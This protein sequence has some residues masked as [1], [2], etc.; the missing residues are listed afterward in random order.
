[1]DYTGWYKTYSGT[2]TGMVVDQNGSV[3]L[4][5]QANAPTHLD[6]V[7]DIT[8]ASLYTGNID[9]SAITVNGV[10]TLSNGLTVT[11]DASFNDK[12]T[13]TG[14]NVTDLQGGLT[15]TGDTSFNDKLTVTSG[16]VTDLQGGLTVTGA[17]TSLQQGLTVTGAVASLQ[18]G[19][20]V[21][22][23]STLSGVLTVN[24]DASLNNGLTV[25]QATDLQGGLTVTGA[26]TSL[27]DLTVTGAA[28]LNSGL[29]VTGAV[30]DLQGGLTVSG[31]ITLQ[32]GTGGTWSIDNGLFDGNAATATDAQ[33]DDFVI[34]KLTISA[35]TIP[36]SD[37][38]AYIKHHSAGGSPYTITFKNMYSGPSIPDETDLKVKNGRVLCDRI[39]FTSYSNSATRDYEEYIERSGSDAMTYGGSLVNHKFP[40]G[41][42]EGNVWTINS[43]GV[44][45]GTATNAT[46]AY[47]AK[48]DTFTIKRDGQDDWYL[49]SLGNNSFYISQSGINPPGG[50]LQIHKN[51]QINSL[52]AATPWTINTN[53]QFDG[54]AATATKASSGYFEIGNV[55]IIDQAGGEILLNRNGGTTNHYFSGNGQYSGNAAT[56]TY[57]TSAG[58]A[59]SSTGD[60]TCGNKLIFQEKEYI[61]RSGFD[62]MTYGT[63]DVLHKFGKIEIQNDETEVNTEAPTPGARS[64]TLL[65]LKSDTYYWYINIA[66]DSKDQ[67]G[68]GDGGILGALLFRRQGDYNAGGYISYTNYDNNLHNFTGQHRC[69]SKNSE[70][71]DIS[72]AGFIVCSTGRYK[73]INSATQ[74]N[75]ENI[76]INECLPYV[77][78]SMS[79]MQQCVFGVIS[80]IEDPNSNSRTYT[81]GVFG[82]FAPKHVGDR[83]L[84]VNSLGEGAIW[85]SDINGP[86][87]N[88]DYITSSDIPGIGMKQDSNQLMN[89]TVAKITMDCDFKCKLEPKMVAK[90]VTTTTSTQVQKKE[91][92]TKVTKETKVEL[93]EA[94]GRYVQKEVEN[95]TSETVDVTEE[96]D[97]YDAEG[98]IIGKHTV[99]VYE[100]V[101][102]TKE[103]LVVDADGNLEYTHELDESGNIVMV[104]E[105]KTRYVK[106][107]GSIISKEEYDDAKT[108]DPDAKVYIMAFVGCTYHCG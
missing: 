19:L 58:S 54:N 52:N 47:N 101:D 55:R 38:D 51:G 62:T 67:F 106:L 90:T 71:Y 63:K 18:Q 50:G 88:G 97:L 30:T 94:T 27:E 91:T 42:I 68:S 35:S 105:Y 65:T 21:T 33:N 46:N 61:H 69:V 73:T 56:A 6:T 48:T 13:V 76:T 10:S 17:V 99:P 81:Q 9:A 92:V 40:S 87:E 83:R 7:T 16:N 74:N 23:D 70:L 2:K 96:V 86:L 107:D 31:V 32:N 49:H 95:E 26:V 57:A 14:G 24:G 103:E 34:G 85:V 100:T 98:N 108:H 60:F 20:T 44:F 29:T 28:S 4:F 104:P 78:V 41:K 22:N 59:T 3:I 75:V 43:Q 102:E 45:N 8:K 12:L 79:S 36:G 53:G 82:S 39:V 93:D 5:S 37:S 77:N 80:N 66:R 72:S 11:G 89:Y 1:M 84:I 15:V 64:K 25:K